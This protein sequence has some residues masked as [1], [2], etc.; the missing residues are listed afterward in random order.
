MQYLKSLF[1]KMVS[2]QADSKLIE[3]KKEEI[4]TLKKEIE[5]I[6]YEISKSRLR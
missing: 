5:K 6:E 4:E 1:S 3:Q 2:T